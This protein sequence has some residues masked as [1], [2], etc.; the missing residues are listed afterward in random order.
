MRSCTDS[1][2][3]HSLGTP[4]KVLV[5]MHLDKLAKLFLCMNLARLSHKYHERHIGIIIILGT[6]NILKF[7]VSVIG[8]NI[9][10]F[11]F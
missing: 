2:T 10:V 6:H 9:D 5:R 7:S 11:F 1:I 4:L 8:E 3:A